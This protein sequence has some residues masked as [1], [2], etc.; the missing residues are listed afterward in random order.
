LS[1]AGAHELYDAVAA[2]IIV[3]V[4]DAITEAYL[5]KLWDDNEIRILVAGSAPTVEAAATDARKAGL[6][7]VFGIRDRDF[8][9]TNFGTW[10]DY[11]KEIRVFRLRRHEMENYLLD[12]GALAGCRE[13][14]RGKKAHDIEAEVK[15]HAASLDWW[16]A[17]KR[18]LFD[19]STKLTKGFPASPGQTKIKTHQGAVA[20]VLQGSKW[21]RHVCNLPETALKEANIRALLMKHHESV[22][23]AL[24]TEEWIEVFPGKELLSKAKESIRTRPRAVK[25]S[26]DTPN[27]AKAVAEWQRPNPKKKED[28]RPP[29]L[30]T[31]RNSLHQRVSSK[32]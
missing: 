32:S 5:N 20:F 16:L 1:S 25:K 10:T 4:E 19:L 3:W 14:R 31:L 24:S 13:N 6:K 18:T 9:K 29:D 11:G 7:N 15:D 28:L 12:W 23:K 2:P 17:T 27:L 8:G 26:A 21:Y 22:Q 30:M